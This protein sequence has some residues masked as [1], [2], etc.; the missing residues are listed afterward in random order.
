GG[1]RSR[2]DAAVRRQPAAARAQRRRAHRPPP[3]RRER[4]RLHLA[5]R[6]PGDLRRGDRGFSRP[7][8][9]LARQALLALVLPVAARAPGRR[10]A[11]GGA[12]D[13]ADVRAP[14]VLVHRRDR[15]PR[16]AGRAALPRLRPLVRRV[17]LR[18]GGSLRLDGPARVPVG[19][20]LPPGGGDAGALRLPAR[21]GRGPR[22][23]QPPRQPDPRSLL[24]RRVE[25]RLLKLGAPIWPP[26]PQ[27]SGR[28]GK[29]GAALVKPRVD[30]PPPPRRGGPRQAVLTR[31]QLLAGAAL[32]VAAGGCRPSAAAPIEGE[33]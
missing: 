18:A 16:G 1:P 17:G 3:A 23:D 2:D 27:R 8:Q 24:R 26:D 7:A 30:T 4:R 14:L 29:A 13:L 22:R 33:I 5:E 6:H 31:R 15:A 32:A 10:R 19:P 12:G 11:R 9:L 20:A 21:H 25:S 28:P